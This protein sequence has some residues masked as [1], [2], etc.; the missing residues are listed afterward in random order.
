[1]DPSD[2]PRAPSRRR[3]G[4]A[5]AAALT[6]AAAPA[7][8][9]AA[10]AL[11]PPETPGPFPGD[12]SN[13]RAG[14]VADV[15]RLDGVVR[16]D[17]RASIGTPSRADGVPM[18]LAL[19]LLDPAGGC[20]PLAGLPVYVWHCDRLGRYSMYDRELLDVNYL[21][22]V[23]LSD[24]EG[25][26]QFDTV[27]PGC[28]GGRYPHLHVQV[29]G[30]DGFA[31]AT[32]RLVTQIA[33]PADACRAVYDGVAGYRESAGHLRRVSLQSDGVFRDGVEHQ[34]ARMQGSPAQGYR[35]S[36]D[37]VLPG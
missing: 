26:L 1:M 13:A 17:L 21:R 9:A 2:P 7:V 24:A 5:A 27:V 14:V 33:L 29:Y 32:P 4:R 30:R 12:G 3:F 35:A 6:F 16:R 36:L 34:L 10:C 22:G 28:Y 11:T 31:G 25:S 8:R 15:L 23:Q 37:L 19:R 18:T 20:R